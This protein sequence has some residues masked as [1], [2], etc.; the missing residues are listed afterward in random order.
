M[1]FFSIIVDDYKKGNVTIRLFVANKT[2]QISILGTL[3]NPKYSNQ[4]PQ[5]SLISP[6]KEFLL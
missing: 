3:F 4:I 5:K 6:N 1:L 2:I